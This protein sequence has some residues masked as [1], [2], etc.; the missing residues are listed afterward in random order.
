V[1]H[2]GLVLLTLSSSHPERTLSMASWF[3]W[4]LR[5]LWTRKSFLRHQNRAEIAA[6]NDRDNAATTGNISSLMQI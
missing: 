2:C 1:G 6:V 5:G 4:P 3:S